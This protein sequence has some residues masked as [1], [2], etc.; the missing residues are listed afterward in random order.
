MK[1]AYLRSPNTTYYLQKTGFLDEVEVLKP[2]FAE[3]GF[4][5][6][7]VNWQDPKVDWQQFD[8]VIPK[9][10][11]DYFDCHDQFT[12]WLDRM[13]QAK[14]PVRN[15]T[16]LIRWNSEK[17]YLLELQKKGASIAPLTILQNEETLFH[18][19]TEIK[20][21]RVV[22]KPLVSGGGKQTDVFAKENRTAIQT[23][24]KA[25][26]KKGP[27][28]LQPY[29]EKVSQGE[30]SFFFFGGEFS[31]A[32]VKIPKPG[33]FRAHKLFGATM[34][35]IK[36]SSEEIRMAANYL[37]HLPCQQHYARADVILVKK[38]FF[39]IEL[40]LIEPYLYLEYAD[41]KAITSFVHTVSE[42]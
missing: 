31:H 29:L 33:D 25:I 4:Q 13:D 16:E 12:Q 14:I 2:Y 28:L 6:V 42:N 21:N 35:A 30:Y 37:E 1:I 39:L 11:W 8:F 26:L 9:N 22:V 19:L 10:A 15:A 20:T 23:A 27:A 32:V 34:K 36:P 5:L 41:T 40:E 3:L 7:S 17:G 38:S 24:V 18:A